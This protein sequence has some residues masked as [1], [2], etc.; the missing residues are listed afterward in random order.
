[1]GEMDQ[2]KVFTL[3]EANRLLPRLSPM[4]KEMQTLRSSILNLEVEIDSL[5][6]VSEKDE[7]GNGNSPALNRKIDEYTRTVKRFYTLVDEI[8]ELG[9]FIKD[10]DLGLV[11]FYSMHKGR[12]V[13]LCWKLGEPSVVYWHEIGRGFSSRQ[14]VVQK[15]FDSGSGRHP[16]KGK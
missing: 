8:H 11:D 9:C 4:L 6:L 1:M 15:D 7:E 2:L 12:V 3:E 5:E 16:E 14:P 13:Y 10:I